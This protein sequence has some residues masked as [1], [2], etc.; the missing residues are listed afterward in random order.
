MT[1]AAL[2]IGASLAL[3]AFVSSPPQPPAPPASDPATPVEPAVNSSNTF[4]VGLYRQ[5][6]AGEPG[7]NLFISP[8]SVSVALT[9][10]AEGARGQTEAQMTSVLAF[11]PVAGGGERS[12][13]AVHR[14]HAALAA[15]FQA[16][17]GSADPQV[18][19]RIGDLKAKLDA[20]NKKIQKLESEGS[21]NNRAIYAEAQECAKELNTL[22]PTV[23]RFDLRVANA[24]W[25]EKTFKLI[26][27]FVDTIGRYYR[28]DGVTAADFK[29]AAERER[30]R[31]NMWVE[32][33][34]EKRIVDLIPSGAV[35]PATALVITN[36]VYFKGQWADPFEASSTRDEDFTL[37][38]GAIAKVK[39]MHDSW[40][41]GVPYAAFT[42]AGE[43]FVTPKEVPADPAD[44]ARPATYPGDDGFSMMELPYKGGD[45]A[46][47]LIAPRTA[48]GMP[49]LEQRLTATNIA[50]W[51]SRFDRRAVDTAMPRFKME[52]QQSMNG[53]LQA[54]GMQRAFVSPDLAQ[55]AEFA[56]IS[57]GP[58]PEDNLFIGLV[59]HKAWVEVTEKGT[60]AAAATAINMLTASAVPQPPK[61]IP[62]T[63][64]FHADHPFIFVIRD[65]K[66]GVILFMGRM[67]NPSA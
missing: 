38:D 44:P 28:T 59:Q 25:V 63:P 6:C 20:A 11:P 51:L 46:M 8:Y 23:D 31:I 22:L 30:G 41:G 61:L 26:P 53:P 29:N 45:L 60:E 49:A 40:R 42:G 19:A 17:S 57:T 65:T 2:L 54:M 15:R 9:M 32:D 33:H 24:L 18:R 1:S 55:G 47:T 56:G 37:A 50:D 5:L 58:R 13:S 4:G 10:A 34:T 12:V 36:A 7:R 66:S 39:M 52:F 48:A 3:P 21:W 67:M 16:A 43:Y 27:S 62:F 14:A 35:T 64:R